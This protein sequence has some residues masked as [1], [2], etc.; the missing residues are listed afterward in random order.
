MISPWYALIFKDIERI[1]N[2]FG[3]AIA[4][5]GSLQR[6]LDL[7]A[8]PWTDDAE[9]KEK[10]LEALK[11]YMAGKGI[12]YKIAEPTQKPHGRLSYI[13][14]V[15]IYSNG[16]YIDLSVMPRAKDDHE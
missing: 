15:G 11:K 9:P 5:H 12:D 4:I 6:D 1:G 13:L 3:Y 10:L 14:S 8:I 16:M 7:I 2:R